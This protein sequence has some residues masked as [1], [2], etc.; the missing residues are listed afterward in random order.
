M[1]VGKISR[2]VENLTEKFHGMDEKLKTLTNLIADIVAQ[3]RERKR[4]YETR[5]P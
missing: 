4:K 1:R 3:A 5:K 2:K